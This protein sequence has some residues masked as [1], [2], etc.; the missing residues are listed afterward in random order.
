[1]TVNNY[2][3]FWVKIIILIWYTPYF[4]SGTY[5]SCKNFEIR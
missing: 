2:I 4:L 5:G 1:M 3:D